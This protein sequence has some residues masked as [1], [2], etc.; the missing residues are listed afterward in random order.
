MEPRKGRQLDPSRPVE[1]YRNLNRGGYS[2]R[3][4]GLVRA[5]TDAVALSE[6]TFVVSRCGWERYRAA[7]RRMVHAWVR[8]RLVS[9]A[10]DAARSA[11]GLTR[12]RYDLGR[13]VFFVPGHPA[14]DV[15]A[16]RVVAM[17]AR[18]AFGEGFV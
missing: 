2:I 3:Q 13:G 18:G 5:Y 17:D 4:G 11:P 12:F 7:G 16:A 15:R 1:V 8:G 6:V 14:R 10:P 9:T